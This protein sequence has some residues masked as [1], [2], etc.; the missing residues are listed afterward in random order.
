[1]HGSLG[2]DKRA[3]P[4]ARSDADFATEWNGDEW[5]MVEADRRGGK[6]KFR[7]PF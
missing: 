1:M 2:V 4:F 5:C 7:C 6:N 3:G